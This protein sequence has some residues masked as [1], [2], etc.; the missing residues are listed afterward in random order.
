MQFENNWMRKI[1]R[2]AKL[3]EALTC[4]VIFVFDFA[5][6]RS[7][8]VFICT[9]STVGGTDRQLQHHVC[10]LSRLIIDV[11]TQRPKLSF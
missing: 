10:Q 11:I 1:P 2:T 5:D 6:Q 3:D 9:L 7:F 8:V 4:A